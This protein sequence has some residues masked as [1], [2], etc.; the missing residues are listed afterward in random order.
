MKK[1][2]II[3]VIL[4]IFGAGLLIFLN[5]SKTPNEESTEKSVT[6]ST[7][8]KESGMKIESSSFSQNSLI[9]A[10]YTCDG[11]NINPPL[12]VTGVP[13]GT[14]SLALIVDDPDAVNGTWTHWTV[15]NISPD[16][17]EIEEGTIPL[18]GI[19]G[20]T[21]FGE[22][23]YGGPCPPSGEHRYF[24]KLYAL[25]TMLDLESGASRA[26]LE[27]AMEG[28]VDDTAQLV[29]LYSRE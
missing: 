1:V 19:E 10:K 2:L 7:Q 27:K 21:S 23:G 26:E 22:P 25:N 12:R 13:E 20:D 18:D 6:S 16:T 24:F 3:T 4:V 14:T 5:L 15:W 29:G 28:H 9:P 8:E 17:T 11:E